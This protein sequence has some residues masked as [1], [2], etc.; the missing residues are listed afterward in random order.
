MFKLNIESTKDI[1]ELHI[2]FADGSSVVTTT[3]NHN[4][5]STSGVPVHDVAA[6]TQKS[7]V[8]REEFLDLDADFG[9]VSQEVV[10]PPEINRSDRPVNVANELQNLD[11]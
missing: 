2:K 9:G 10:K 3:S 5:A 8:R 4:L 6:Q 1:N 11:I 7:S